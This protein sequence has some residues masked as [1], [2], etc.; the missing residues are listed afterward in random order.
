MKR[1][2]EIRDSPMPATESTVWSW[3]PDPM[4]SLMDLAVATGSH[5]LNLGFKCGKH[6]GEVGDAGR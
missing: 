2:K 4:S 1:E 5:V 6:C 3:P